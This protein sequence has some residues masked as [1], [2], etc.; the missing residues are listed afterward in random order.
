[1]AKKSNK[2]V[3]FFLRESLLPIAI[4]GV[5][6]NV[7]AIKKITF[8]GFPKESRIKKVLLLMDRPLRGGFRLP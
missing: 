1:M 6:L 5:G 2:R 3:I 4:K 7:T 8:C